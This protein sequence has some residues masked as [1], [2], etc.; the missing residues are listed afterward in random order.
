MRILRLRLANLGP[1]VRPVGIDFTQLGLDGPF[2][3]EGPTGAG[4]TT[5]IDAIVFA[6]YGKVSGRDSDDAR[7]VS[8]FRAPGDAPWVELTLETRHGL[9]RVWRSPAYTRPSKRAASGQAIEKTAVKLWKLADPDDI[10]TPVSARHDEIA[11]EL[12]QA[13]G[14]SREQFTQTVVLPQGDFASFLRATPEDR[15]GILTRVFGTQIYD[16]LLAQLDAA[17]KESAKAVEA[18]IGTWVAAA[19]AFAAI[20]WPGGADEGFTGAVDEHDTDAADALARQRCGALGAARAQAAQAAQQAQDELDAARR[21][22]ADI[23]RDNALV[24]QRAHLLAEQ[25]RLS[26][27]AGEVDAERAVLAAAE[28]AERVRRPLAARERAQEALVGAQ[29]R[30]EVAKVGAHAVVFDGWDDA[31]GVWTDA[32]GA[33]AV[34]PGMTAG[35]LLVEQQRAEVTAWQ[36]RADAVAAAQDRCRQAEEALQKRTDALAQAQTAADRAQTALDDLGHELEQA[37]QRA[38]GLTAAQ[39]AERAARQVRQQV[40]DRDRL[41]QERAERQA[42][43]DE[44]VAGLG[45]ATRRHHDL[46]AAW[47]AGLAG[48]LAAELADAQPCPVCGSC[49]HPAPARRQPGQASRDEVDAAADAEAA[50]VRA[51]TEAR[52]QQALAD[53]A[54]SR[55]DADAAG[56]AESE[57]GQRWQAAVAAV[58]DCEQAER[59]AAEL[60]ESV[61]GQQARL[62]QLREQASALRE[63]V[64][65]RHG[66]LTA[67]LASAEAERAAL[68]EQ[69]QAWG[70]VDVRAQALDARAQALDGLIEAARGFAAAARAA[71]TCAA[72]LDQALSEAEFADAGAARAALVPVAQA[73]VRAQA[74]AEHDAQVA[75]VQAQLAAEAM[76][77]AAALATVDAVPAQQRVEQAQADAQ[78]AHELLGA[79]DRT[80]AGAQGA[81]AVMRARADDLARQRAEHEPR[82]HMRAVAGGDNQLSMTLPTF[83]LLERF[84]E[85]L[86][87]ANQ[88]LVAM[89]DGRYELERSEDREGRTRRQG[90]GLQM[91]DHEAGDVRRATRTL[92]GG[93]TFLTSLALALGLSDAVTAEA[94]GIELGTLLVD[95]GFGSLDGENLDRVMSQFAAL[96]GDGR[97]VGVISHVEELKSRI[98]DRISVRALGDGTSVVA[99]AIPGVLLD[100]EEARREITGQ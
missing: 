99:C 77:R 34:L 28:R 27:H 81:E 41:A 93:E 7:L 42:G 21:V 5:L 31:W 89:T 8:T 29:D 54:W 20:A 51:L 15:K 68:A 70:G 1:Y 78:H 32:P 79:A 61:A 9:Y 67:M 72:D 36:A 33:E 17:G 63:T 62:A 94:G 60:A 6:L 53:Q 75:G 83:V 64:D 22:L 52:T 66:E 92:S 12:E 49:E 71:A 48:D 35:R 59:R 23:E 50:A 11:H 90:L 98:H 87:L 55:A 57:A 38:S 82:A 56:L 100:T 44:A 76:V 24:E 2:L 16:G 69:E 73:K 46:H 80:D 25:Q 45:E 19:S 91:I 74:V 47:L 43:L 13:V 84:D 14:L 96:R 4:K 58:Q 40:A 3:L 88:R 39:A 37:Q 30:A 10:G 18:A 65:R 97:Q 85:V 95:E 86:E 26:E